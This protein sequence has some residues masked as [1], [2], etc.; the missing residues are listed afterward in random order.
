MKAD[1]SEK[2]I[3][4]L[5]LE[6]GRRIRQLR[7]R[8]KLTQLRLAQELGMSRTSVTNVEIGR[9]RLLIHQ[10][11]RLAQILGVPPSELLPPLDQ[12]T[13]NPRKPLEYSKETAAWVERA[14][15]IAR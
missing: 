6:L 3:D 8:R 4:D 12:P 13:E 5:Y 7:E 1:R 14:K 9:Q 10:F 11:V 2:D 15:S